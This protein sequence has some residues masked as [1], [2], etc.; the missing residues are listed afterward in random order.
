MVGAEGHLLEKRAVSDVV[1]ANGAVG[2][3]DND[4]VPRLKADADHLDLLGRGPDQALLELEVTIF[5]RVHDEIAVD[6]A[7]D[8]LSWGVEVGGRGLNAEAPDLAVLAA[9]VLLCAGL[10]EVPFGDCVGVADTEQT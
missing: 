8:E 5:D 3:A 1:G 4:N 9:R 7:G 2:A 10:F 6:S